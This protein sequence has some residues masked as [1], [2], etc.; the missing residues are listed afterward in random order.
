M[1]KKNAE[2]AIAIS[3]LTEEETAR[4]IPYL[5]QRHIKKG[6]Q[7]VTIGKIAKEAYFLLRGCMRLYYQK[8]DISISG[9]FFTERMF[10][11]ACES[12][13]GQKPS[14]HIIEA[15]ED[16]DVLVISHQRLQKLFSELPMMNALFRRIMEERF[17]TIHGLFTSQILDSP[18]ERYIN[19]VKNN[20]TLHNRIPLHQIATYIGVTPVSLSRIRSRL[21]NH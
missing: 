7:V 16:C 13:I 8:K 15:V 10:T 14:R 9:Y 17:E 2:K 19:F 1:K 11:G 6:T 4:L 3:G 21:K 12:F 20:P 5:E 18:K